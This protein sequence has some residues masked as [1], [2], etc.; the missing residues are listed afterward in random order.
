VRLLVLIV[1]KVA[2]R[3]ISIIF[4][5]SFFVGHHFLVETFLLGLCEFP[6]GDLETTA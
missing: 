1:L 6:E 4:R 3:Q 5:R 2:V